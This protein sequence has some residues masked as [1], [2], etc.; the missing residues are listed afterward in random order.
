MTPALPARRALHRG[1]VAAVVAFALAPSAAVAADGVYKCSSGGRVAY[2][3]HPCDGAREG[4][5]GD[6]QDLSVLFARVRA[7]EQELTA[8]ELARSGQMQAL[9]KKRRRAADPAPVAAEIATVEREWSQRLAATRAR[10]DA[11]LATIR[12]RCPRGA[13]ETD[14]RTT[15]AR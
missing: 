5:R 12:A 15:C 13:S 2:Q 1:L 6:A 7:S 4:A 3:D 8:L 11:T 10:R 14:G 9:E